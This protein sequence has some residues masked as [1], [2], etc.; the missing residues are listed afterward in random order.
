M[1]LCYGKQVAVLQER[2]NHESA[3]DNTYM[4][5]AFDDEINLNDIEQP[6]HLMVYDLGL[7][8][9]D[10]RLA[11]PPACHGDLAMSEEPQTTNARSRQT[12]TPK[13]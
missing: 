3:S 12:A 10:V 9:G 2:M 5:P 13:V 6:K 4:G 11:Q 7:S 1:L 8:D